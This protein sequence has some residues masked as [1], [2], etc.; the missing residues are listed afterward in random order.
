MGVSAVA[1]VSA[2]SLFAFA[3]T[4]TAAR[5]VV[6]VGRVGHMGL[7][8]VWRHTWG[9]SLN[10]RCCHASGGAQESCLAIEMLASVGS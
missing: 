2:T 3:S 8:V 7:L 6:T 1:I 4:T 10:R 9:K 5:G